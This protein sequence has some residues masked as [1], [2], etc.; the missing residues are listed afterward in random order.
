MQCLVKSLRKKLLYY[1]IIFRIKPIATESATESYSDCTLAKKKLRFV[2]YSNYS[3]YVSFSS[4]DQGQIGIKLGAKHV[5]Y[6]KL[7]SFT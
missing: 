6:L 1:N 2:Q 5:I 3:N 4:S 7:A